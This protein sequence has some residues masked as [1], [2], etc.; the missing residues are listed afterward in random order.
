MAATRGCYGVIKVKAV[1]ATS[2]ALTIGQ[3]KEWSNEETAEQVDTS[4]I[5]TCTKTFQAG[6]VGTNGSFSAYWSQSTGDN[7]ALL[8]VGNENYFEIYPAG[9][10]SGNTYYKTG[11]TTGNGAVITSVSRS[12]SV[13]GMVESQIGYVVN[14]GLTATAVP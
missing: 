3:I 2:S 9:T 5:G 8:A 4:S 10:G 13:D 6:A 7:H 12:G 14:G 1:G 11:N